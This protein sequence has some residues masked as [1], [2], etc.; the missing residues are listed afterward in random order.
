[1]SGNLRC[2]CPF[3]AIFACSTRQAPC[4][5]EGSPLGRARSL[6]ESSGSPARLAVDDERDQLPSVAD[7]EIAIARTLEAVLIV[8]FFGDLDP[9]PRTASIVRLG[10]AEL[11]LAGLRE[12]VGVLLD[13][14]LAAL[15]LHCYGVEV[16]GPGDPDH[17]RDCERPLESAASAGRAPVAAPQRTA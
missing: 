15:Q 8:L 1:R 7:I 10:R 4:Q 16:Q 5:K 11:L 13:A 6:H 9:E 17:Q 2:V 14:G 3:H 12:L